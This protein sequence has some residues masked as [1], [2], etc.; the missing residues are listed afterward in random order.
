LI[1][2]EETVK[3]VWERDGVGVLYCLKRRRRRRY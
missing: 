2:R 1:F 3:W